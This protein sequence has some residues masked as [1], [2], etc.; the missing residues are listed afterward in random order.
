MPFS[1]YKS[2]IYSWNVSALCGLSTQINKFMIEYDALKHSPMLPVADLFL[3]IYM[4]HLS[5]T[6]KVIFNFFL[7][8]WIKPPTNVNVESVRNMSNSIN[9]FHFRLMPVSYFIDSKVN[10]EVKTIVE[11]VYMVRWYVYV[12]FLCLQIT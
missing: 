4:T 1:G 8:S 5:R 11:H 2:W 9:Y 6:E 3:G 7:H 10:V 12:F